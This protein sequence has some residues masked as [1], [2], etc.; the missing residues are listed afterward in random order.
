MNKKQEIDRCRASRPSVSPQ[1]HSSEAARSLDVMVQLGKVISHGDG[2][3]GKFD[4]SEF[5][6]LD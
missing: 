1:S 6:F 4:V 3:W 5:E 2:G